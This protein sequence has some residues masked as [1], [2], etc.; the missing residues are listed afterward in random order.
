MTPPDNC[1][2]HFKVERLRPQGTCYIKVDQGGSPGREATG[3]ALS[4][5]PLPV[6]GAFLEGKRVAHAK[7]GGLGARLEGTGTR[8][9]SWLLRSHPKHP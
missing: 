1:Q 6:V 7:T 2:S 4:L 5:P 8:G 3:R 9:W